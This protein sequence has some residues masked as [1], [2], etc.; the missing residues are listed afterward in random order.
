MQI[1][2]TLA[3]LLAL[4]VTGSGLAISSSIFCPTQAEAKCC[5]KKAKGCKTSCKKACKGKDIVDT[6]KTS[7][8]FKTLSGALTTSG[9]S[10]TL[11]GC[12]PFT[13]FAPSDSAFAKL[14][15]AEKEELLA[16]E[17]RL[18][19]VLKYHVVKGV[20]PASELAQK[21]AI[22]TVQGESLML[23]TKNDGETLIVDGAIVTQPDIKCRNGVIHVI[24]ILLVPER[25][26]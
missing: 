17:K 12:G 9:L 15:K 22:T 13:V 3:T 1:K 7:E 24:D 11:H 19:E 10:R 5:K 2:G 26:K 8:D 20:F 18:P 6:A 4:T 23:D 16:D 21:R 25:G 14:P